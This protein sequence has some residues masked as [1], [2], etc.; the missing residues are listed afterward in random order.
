MSDRF[1]KIYLLTMIVGSFLIYMVYYYY[2]A[3]FMKAHYKIVEF[4]HIEVKASI[5]DKVAYD[6]NSKTQ[7]LKY[8]NEQDSLITEKVVLPEATIKEIHQKMWDQMFFDMP[9]QMIG[10]PEATTP[11]YFINMCYQK[12]CKSIVWDD[13]AMQKP[14]YMER[15]RELKKFI[16]TKIEESETK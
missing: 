8:R 14:Q 16:E 7:L 13:K 2:T 4:D 10:G 5:G 11:R 9:D 12:K 6:Y 3:Y 1:K 15:V